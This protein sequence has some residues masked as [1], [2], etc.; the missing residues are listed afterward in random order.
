MQV[1]ILKYVKKIPGGMMVVPL[2]L[3]MLCNTFFPQFLKIGGLSTALWGPAAAAPFMAMCM[4]GMGANIHV[5]ALAESLKR[6]AVLTLAK[7][8]AGAIIGIIVGKLFGAAGVLGIS[9]LAII[10]SVTNSNGG[11]YMSLAAQYG[12]GVDVG[13]Q[14]V[15][16]LNDGPFLTMVAFSLSG[17][18]DIPFMTLIAALLPLVLGMILGNLDHELANFLKPLGAICIPFFAFPLGAAINLGNVFKSGISGTLLG[19]FCVAWSGL[20]CILADKFINRRPGFAG[21]A[22]ASAAGNCVST[23]ALVAAADPNLAPLVESATVQ[24]AAAVVVTAILVPFVT[25]WAAKKWG[26]S[27]EFD[28]KKAE[29]KAAKEKAAAEA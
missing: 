25:A 22:I 1:P 7:F 13:A 5:K 4:F 24:C 17:M 28:A 29:I 8:A 21:A 11:L 14:S 27:Q 12:D 10:S 23:P 20:I 26:T 9:S 3:G 18:A 15:L 16:G 2:F 19:L 6:G